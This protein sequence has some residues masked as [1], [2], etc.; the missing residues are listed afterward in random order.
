MLASYFLLPVLALAT[1]SLYKRD[2]ASIT[3][4][5]S[6]VNSNIT[7]VNNTL[8]TFNKPKDSITALKIQVHTTELTKSVNSAA[9]V[10][11]AS[12]PLSN[13]EEFDV[14]TAVLNLQP[15]INSLLDNVVAHKPQFGTAI[16]GFSASPLVKKDL[17]DAEKAADA[18]GAALTPKLSGAY[19]QAAPIIV[20]QI[21]AKFDEAIKQFSS[22][23]PF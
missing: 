17:Q 7:A 20:Q 3:Q 1:P 9:S 8:N 23:S 14:A 16:F 21:D 5:I 22:A 4:A 11:N 2:G 18:F 13:S 6:Y 19:Q 15:N 12:A 10:A